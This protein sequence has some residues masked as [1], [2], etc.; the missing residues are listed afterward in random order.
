VF[1]EDRK[2][3]LVFRCTQRSFRAQLRAAFAVVCT[4]IIIILL[5]FSSSSSFLHVI[6]VYYS[7][8]NPQYELN[9]TES[10]V[11]ISSAA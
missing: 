9:T 11:L 7:Q 6:I 3:A 2:L 8:G 10:R 1:D 4:H 5:L